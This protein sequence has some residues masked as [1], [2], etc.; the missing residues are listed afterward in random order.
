M[1]SAAAVATACWLDAVTVGVAVDAAVAIAAP[2]TPV[3]TRCEPE[4]ASPF[5]VAEGQLA[6][7]V[8]LPTETAAEERTTPPDS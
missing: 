2:E 5:P 4:T 6:P 1:E 3:A 8:A 7:L